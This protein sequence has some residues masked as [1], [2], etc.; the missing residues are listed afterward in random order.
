MN[1]IAEKVV[2]I[3][4]DEELETLILSN[5]ENDAQTLTPG[6]SRTC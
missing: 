3:M 4:N 1:R 6:P 2:P 5:Y